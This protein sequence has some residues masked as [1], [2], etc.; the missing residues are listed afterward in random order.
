MRPAASC[1]D[2]SGRDPG[3]RRAGWSAAGYLAPEH[4]GYLADIERKMAAWGLTDHFDNLGAVDRAG[5]I[6]FLADARA[7]S[8]SLSLP[9][10]EGTVPPRG[11]GK[12]RAGR[13][14]AASARSPR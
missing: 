2:A 8:R 12:R 1:T 6:A 9:H 14:T 7:S 13:R 10:S 4:K 5:K 3:A 11:D